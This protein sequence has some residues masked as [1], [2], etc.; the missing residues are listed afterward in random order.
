MS[1]LGKIIEID[2]L[3]S[4]E[5]HLIGLVLII[6]RIHLEFVDILFLMVANSPLILL[7]ELLQI[8]T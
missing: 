8:V 3:E 6:A 4:Q 1:D 5:I 2:H 7:A